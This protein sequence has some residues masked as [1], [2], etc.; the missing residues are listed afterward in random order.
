MD[1]KKNNVKLSVKYDLPPVEITQNILSRF[2]SQGGLQELLSAVWAEEPSELEGVTVKSG[3]RVSSQA[4]FLLISL[5]S[6]PSMNFTPAMTSASCL[7]PRSRRQR[8]CALIAS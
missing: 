6:T 2:A 7:K 1:L 8:F 5:S 4:A 3:V